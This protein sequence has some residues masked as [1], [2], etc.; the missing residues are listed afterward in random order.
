MTTTHVRK[1][2]VTYEFSLAY[3]DF[4][5]DSEFCG[6]FPPGTVDALEKQ[7]AEVETPNR[8]LSQLTV[9]EGVFRFR[10]YDRLTATV[11]DG[12]EQF[13]LRSQELNYSPWY[14]CGGEEGRLYTQEMAIPENEEICEL[15]YRQSMLERMRENG[16]QR[17]FQTSCGWQ[18]GCAKEFALTPQ[19]VFLP[20]G[21]LTLVDF[22]AA[23]H[24]DV[25]LL[26]L[27]MGG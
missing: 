4:H 23:K 19:D 26:G 6:Y 16:V 8:E 12:G 5:G 22:L 1:T 18:G 9:P 10:F 25:D 27:E 14:Y 15:E 17:L 24:Q 3:L 2:Y 7:F 11:T 20:K 21:N 13:E